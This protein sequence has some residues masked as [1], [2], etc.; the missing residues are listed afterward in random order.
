MQKQF[1]FR[2][3]SILNDFLNN[4]QKQKSFKV[5]FKTPVTVR[6]CI[7]AFR[8]PVFE[9]GKLLINGNPANLNTELNEHD[10][11]SIY[12]HF[13]T[14]YEEGQNLEYKFVLDAHLGKLSRYLRMLGFDTLYKND[15][16]DEEIRQIASTEKRIVL[17]RDK[18]IK[19]TPDPA[20]YYV[21]STEKH[22]Q[23][24]E[25]VNFWGLTHHIQ[26]FT[27]CMTCNSPLSK[28]QVEQVRDKLDNDIADR[29]DEFYICKKCDKVFWK[30]SHF[31]RME[32]QILDLI[33]SHGK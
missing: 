12:P 5:T 30:G 7:M 16:L 9:I 29:F 23:L 8:I 32:K 11:I 2:F 27:R 1:T 20:Y 4:N 15:Y 21:R 18:L 22:Q 33:Q 31:K 24:R 14:I 10:R 28:V 26:P 17:T 6:E 19:N 13:R 3:Y 25:V